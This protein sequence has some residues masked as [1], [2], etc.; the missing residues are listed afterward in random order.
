VRLSAGTAETSRASTKGRTVTFARTE[1]VSSACH[2]VVNRAGTSAKEKCVEAH[3]FISTGPWL[4][5]QN[6]LWRRVHEERGG[7]KKSV[8]GLPEFHGT[9]FGCDISPGSAQHKGGD[10]QAQEHDRCGFG[11]N[12]SYRLDKVQVDGMC[13]ACTVSDAQFS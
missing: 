2:V 8:G 7:T 13:Y 10:T 1:A 5:A 12:P 6:R 9:L 3:F 11:D 4:C